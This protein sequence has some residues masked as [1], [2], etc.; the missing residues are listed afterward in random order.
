LLASALAAR[1]K[2]KGDGYLT[3][4]DLLGR[5]ESKLARRAAATG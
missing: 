2:A 4:N 5:V 1:R 3:G